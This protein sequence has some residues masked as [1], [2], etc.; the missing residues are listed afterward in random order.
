MQIP[1]EAV[2][3]VHLTCRSRIEFFKQNSKK[4]RGIIQLVEYQT[5]ERDFG[6]VMFNCEANEY[7]RNA[8]CELIGWL[9]LEQNELPPS[10]RKMYRIEYTS[11]IEPK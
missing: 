3:E 10:K 6:I 2:Q 8:L 7:N 9:T 4:Q 5:L 1:E 11:F